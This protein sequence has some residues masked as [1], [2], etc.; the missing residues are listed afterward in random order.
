MD[1]MPCLAV[2]E[3]GHCGCE[4]LR[5][6]EAPDVKAVSFSCSH[7]NFVGDLLSFSS[8]A[9]AFQLLRRLEIS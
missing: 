6:I 2:I 4:L 3:I 8:K 5:C 7:T 9:S 1:F